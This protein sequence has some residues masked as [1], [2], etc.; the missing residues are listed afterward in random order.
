MK[1]WQ[2]QAPSNIALIKYMGKENTANNQACNPSLSYTLHDLN[3]TVKLTLSNNVQ[4]TW[5]PLENNNDFSLNLA[6]QDRF[7]SHLNFL[8]QQFDFSG[9]FHV[10][11][12][13][14]FPSNCGLASSAASFAALTQCAMTALCELTKQ[15]LPDH[16]TQAQLSR[17]GSGSSCRSFFSPWCLWD[18]ESLQ[19]LD[20]PYPTLEHEV[21]ILDR[22]SKAISSSEAHQRVKTSSNFVGRSARARTRLETLTEAL[23]QQDWSTAFTLCWQEFWDM[24]QLFTT[25]EKPFQYLTPNSLKALDILYN[26]WQNAGDGPLV[27][28]DA[29]PNIHLLFRPDQAQL[30]K[31]LLNELYGNI[32][33]N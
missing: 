32:Q 23:T 3:S 30:K 28:V 17:V 9:G 13:N 20:L 21:I 11:S 26:F 19:T 22:K 24:H 14:N 10:Q 27:T 7:L 8:K 16:I 18:N 1:S 12:G 4:D 15:P 25:A 33:E 5:Q 6:G 31:T 2:A 29:G